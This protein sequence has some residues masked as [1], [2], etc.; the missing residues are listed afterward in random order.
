MSGENKF[1]CWNCGKLIFEIEYPLH[2]K[3]KWAKEGI[4]CQDCFN[5]AMGLE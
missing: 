3:I 4:Y 1:Y 5:K 2:D